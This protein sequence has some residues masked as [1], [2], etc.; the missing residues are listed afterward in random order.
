MPRL[1]LITAIQVYGPRTSIVTSVVRYDQRCCKV[2]ISCLLSFS[3]IEVLRDYLC[4]FFFCFLLCFL[5][6]VHS[7]KS[8]I[9]FHIVYHILL[10][11][12]FYYHDTPHTFLWSGITRFFFLHRFLS[13][14]IFFFLFPL[15]LLP[16]NFLYSL[17]LIPY[18]VSPLSFLL[19]FS[20][21]FFLSF[22]LSL[23][24]SLH[25]EPLLFAHHPASSHT[26]TT[27]YR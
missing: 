20:S 9:T 13:F 18:S 2:F 11:I 3:F 10:I 7:I 21:F 8:L 19:F 26:I 4:C 22:L 6:L 25:S 24:R 1:F 15:L 17:F 23:P 16:F 12:T 5:F 27:P 14:C